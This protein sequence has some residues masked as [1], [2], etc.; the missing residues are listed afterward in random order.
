MNKKIAFI[1]AGNMAISLIKGLLA[2]GY[3]VTK[4]IATS[5]S[6]SNRQ[7][8]MQ[9]VGVRCIESNIEAI[10]QS[11]IV[12][13]AIKPQVLA[14]VCSNIEDTVI[15]H[16]PLVISVAA[17]IRSTDI[18]RWLG[19]NC[20]VVR[21][22][23]NTPSMIQTG[24]TGLFANSLVSTEQKS[25]AENILRAVGLTVWVDSDEDIDSVTALSGSG[26]AYYFLFME[27]MQQAAENMGLDKKTAKLLTIQ[28]AF[29]AAKMALES[30]DSC[31]DLRK[32]VTSPNGT[33]EQAIK[34]FEANQLPEVVSQAMLAAKNRAI[35]LADELSIAATIKEK[36][37]LTK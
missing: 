30:A 36:P 8:V 17:G 6:E 32:K 28:T 10:T 37:K 3:D 1:G 29:G 33:T 34:S 20:A 31:E 35:S 12:V 16:K 15:K 5:P 21:C 2:S 27:S 7:Q 25:D 9:S 11:D 26:P 18:N 19:G 4:I 24:A 22:M 13:L 14:S 23:P